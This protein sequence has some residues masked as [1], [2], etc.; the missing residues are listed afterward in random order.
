MAAGATISVAGNGA[1]DTARDAAASFTDDANVC[2]SV[3]QM[4]TTSGAGDMLSTP[5]AGGGGT[6]RA[7]A[8]CPRPLAGDAAYAAPDCRHVVMPEPHRGTRLC[9]SPPPVV[10]TGSCVSPPPAKTSTKGG[11]DTAGLI[12]KPEE[13]F[14]QRIQEMSATRHK[15]EFEQEKARKAKKENTDSSTLAWLSK[16]VRGLCKRMSIL[17]Q[18]VDCNKTVV[19]T[20]PKEQMKWE[21]QK[22]AEGMHK[23]REDAAKERCPMS[24]HVEEH[25]E[26]VLKWQR[27]KAGQIQEYM[28]S[29]IQEAQEF[30]CRDI[31][32]DS[33]EG[34]QAVCTDTRAELCMKITEV[35]EKRGHLWH[36]LP[37]LDS[38]QSWP[39]KQ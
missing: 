9:V 5:G 22:R 38:K 26:Q 15:R 34:A 19:G 7:E 36:V 2:S 21:R 32:Q 28:E 16:E 11:T 1:V 4:K 33:D 27:N 18:Y 39:G 31:D 14:I 23:A 20:D 37:Q 30:V 25:R 6:E 10:G 12:N 8:L 29:M 3:K 17:L 13:E 24:R 35:F